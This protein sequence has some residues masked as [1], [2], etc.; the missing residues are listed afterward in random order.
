MKV[1]Y[2]ITKLLWRFLSCFTW[3][4][5]G[6]SWRTGLRDPRSR[7][8]TYNCCLR[9][10]ICQEPVW[11]VW[12]SQVMWCYMHISYL[13]SKFIPCW[14]QTWLYLSCNLNQCPIC[15][16]FKEHYSKWNVPKPKH[17]CQAHQWLPALLTCGTLTEHPYAHQCTCSWSQALFLKGGKVVQMAPFQSLD[18]LG[19]HCIKCQEET[20][21]RSRKVPGFEA[22]SVELRSETRPQVHWCCQWWRPR[23][24]RGWLTESLCWFIQ[25]QPGSWG[26]PGQEQVAISIRTAF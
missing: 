21:R 17:Q 24:M 26:K 22:Q 14:L 16:H 3:E 2:I 25:C 8:V 15:G 13:A 1:L 4:L 23:G 12:Q 7:D 11:S 18:A 9:S 10:K 6:F 5:V 19:E 20:G